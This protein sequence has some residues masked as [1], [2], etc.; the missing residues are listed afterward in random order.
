MAV[1]TIAFVYGAPIG[2]GGLGAQAGNALR[3]L[4]L[5]GSRIHAIG[6]GPGSAGAHHPN[7]TWHVSPTSPAPLL[8]WTPLRRHVGLSQL[9]ADRR[10][11]RFAASIAARV[12][13][14][15]CYAFTQVG[16]ETV[17]WAKAAG[18]P[19][20]IESPNGHIRAFRSVYV[21]EAADLC[22]TKYVGHP[23]LGM[24]ERVE[25]ELALLD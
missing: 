25:E 15:L 4:A 13:A 17:R 21:T 10:V 2:V 5:T 7:V 16:L 19:T 8:L 6:P 18:V 1:R 22:R 20:V 9:W 23:T 11:G 24:V 3:A 14:H 12:K